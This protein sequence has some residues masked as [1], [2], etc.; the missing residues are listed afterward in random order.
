MVGTN[1]K[2]SVGEEV[3]PPLSGRGDGAVSDSGRTVR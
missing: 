1:W 3:W 2:R